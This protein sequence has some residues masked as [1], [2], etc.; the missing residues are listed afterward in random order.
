METETYFFKGLE[1]WIDLNYT[2]KFNEFT[3]CVRNNSQNLAQILYHKDFIFDK[4]LEYISQSDVL[5][6]QPFLE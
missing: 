2:S 1:K 6:V 5:S 4:L 3:L